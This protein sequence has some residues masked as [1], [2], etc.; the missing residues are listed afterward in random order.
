MGYKLTLTKNIENAVLNK[1][2]A[3]NNA[4]I[5]INAFEWRIV[6]H[7]IYSVLQ[8]AILSKQF[9]TKVPTELQYVETSVFMKEIRTQSLWISE[10]GI[11]EGINI[12]IWI[13]IEFQQSERQDSQNSNSQNSNI[14]T[15]YSPPV[16]S[17]QCIFSTEKNPD[18]AFSSNYFDEDYSQGYGRIKEAFRALTKDDILKPYISEKDF[19]S[20]NNGDDVSYN[21]YV[22]DKRYQKNFES[23]HS[24]KVEFKFS[25]NIP[26]GIY[27]YAL[28]LTGKLVSISRDGQKHCD[29]I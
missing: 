15:F 1:K 22:F 8:Q 26:A 27:G 25:G 9:P 19:R 16:I 13:I 14:D 18:S 3:I 12:P 11:Q 10:L 6:P 23:A 21:L 24:F 28:V 20:T 4:K 29:L 2:N 7:F 17:A 5:K